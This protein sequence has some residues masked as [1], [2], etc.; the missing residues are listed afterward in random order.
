MKDEDL[1]RGFLEATL[2][3][4]AFH[5]EQHVRAA[6]LFL[7]RWN[8]GE[9]FSR[10]TSSLR[11]LAAAYG[12]ADRYHDTVTWAY[13]LMVRERLERGDP[14]DDWE[15]FS[16]RNPDLFQP[17]RR[18]LAPH[19]RDSTIDSPLARRVFVWPD[20]LRDIPPP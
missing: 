20:R 2:P 12:K 6:W 3:P 18:M 9:A 11:R 7:R 5:H 16:R 14:G 19:Y 8:A 13:L 1:L 4:E 17:W 10:F 15:R